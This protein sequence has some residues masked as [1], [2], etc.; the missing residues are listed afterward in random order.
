VTFL[1]HGGNLRRIP[2]VRESHCL[3]QYLRCAPGQVCACLPRHDAADNDR[4][5]CTSSRTGWGLLRSNERQTR[6]GPNQ[7]A[8]RVP[9]H[10]R[11]GSVS[12]AM[13]AM[14]V[15]ARKTL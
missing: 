3:A 6:N 4:D 14:H 15:V 1:A 12:P 7:V 10:D 2:A 9:A 8:T 5:D 11:S 13:S